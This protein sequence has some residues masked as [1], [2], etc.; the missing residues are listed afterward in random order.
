MLCWICGSPA[1]APAKDAAGLGELNPQDFAITDAHY[2]RTAPIYTCSACGFRF[3]PDVG[4]ATPYYAALQDEAYE[5]TRPARAFQADKLAAALQQVQPTGAVLDVG[6]GSGIL[7]EQLRARHFDARGVDPSQWL[8]AQAQ[9]RGLPVSQGTFP[10]RELPGPWDAITLVDVLEH[11]NDPVGLLRDIATQLRPGGIALIVTPDAGSLAARTMG[12]RWWHYRLAHIGYF[13]R[14]TLQRAC[15]AAG[16]EPISWQRPTWY[17]PLDYLT[18]RLG[19]YVPGVARL[20]NAR[21]LKR[22]Q[23]PLNLLDSWLVIARRAP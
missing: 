2:G 16:L 11:V 15:T 7:V 21:W 5:A 13:N 19:H 3:C 4:D 10:H 1:D 17:F 20:A 12:P 14:A 23:V 9:Q 18:A 22:V 8:V 6:A